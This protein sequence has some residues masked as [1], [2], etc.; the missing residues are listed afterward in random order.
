LYT[1]EKGEWHAGRFIASTI[2]PWTFFWLNY[3]EGWLITKEWHGDGTPEMRAF[4]D[5]TEKKNPD[6]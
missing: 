2:V 3:Y 4:E 6:D 5:D 1:P